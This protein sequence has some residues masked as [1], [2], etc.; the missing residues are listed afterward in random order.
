MKKIYLSTLVGAF[1]SLSLFSC[2]DLD[3]KVYSS[4]TEQNY[5]YSEV[6]AASENIKQQG[7]AEVRASSF[8]FRFYAV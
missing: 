1:C 7:L 8:G 5:Q 4:I 6:P 3:E 2:S